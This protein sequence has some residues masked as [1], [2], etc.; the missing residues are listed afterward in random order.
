M[1]MRFLITGLLCIIGLA[2]TAQDTAIV[3]FTKEISGEGV[4]KA[5][6]RI[7]SSVTGKV[8]VKVHFGEEG[9]TN[10]LSPELS[11]LLVTTYQGT[12]VESNVL[13]VGKRRYTE[14]H[15]QLARDHGFVYAPVDIL[16]DSGEMEIPVE[17]KHFKVIRA[18]KGLDNYGT[19]IIFSH[20]KGHGSAGFGGAIKNVGMGMAAISGKMA[21]HA[22]TVP[23][24][25]D[26]TRCTRCYLCTDACPVDAIKLDPVR[27]DT[28]KCI[29]CGACIGVCPERI[30]NV[31]W[32][33]T[34]ES[35]FQERMVE[36]TKGMIDGR[37]FLY[38]NVLANI[39][40]ECDCAGRSSK[41]FTE[42]IGILAS[43]DI[44]AIEAASHDL[45]NKGHKCQ[46]AFLKE[47]GVSG[48]TQL[49]Y[50]EKIGMGTPVYKLVEIK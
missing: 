41:P 19:Y 33:S 7:D 16:D 22:S 50:A 9:N 11:R 27:I 3:Y 40:R 30:F 42:D 38:V 8:G 47:T 1:K 46:D 25:R 31:P 44:L 23:L 21:Q 18:P 29:G 45:V 6:S 35:V 5:F 36:Y 20:F 43:T 15:K 49:E 39:A 32:R 2:L 17:M 14:S 12:Y 48:K 26:T 34:E 13:Y 37:N 24:L 28:A 4:M 10:F